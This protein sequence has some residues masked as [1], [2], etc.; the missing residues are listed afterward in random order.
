DQGL[1][2]YAEAV[3]ALQGINGNDI[4]T[5]SAVLAQI[6]ILWHLLSFKDDLLAAD[7]FPDIAISDKANSIASVSAELEKHGRFIELDRP[8]YAG[9]GGNPPY[10]RPERA[11]EADPSTRRYF[12]GGFDRWPGI[13]VEANL[14]ALFVY[15]AL[16]HWCKPGNKWGEGS[17]KLGFVLP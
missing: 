8:V 10:V 16:D 17:G 9:V 13:S 11:P 15:R 14:Y 1:A 3:K 7:E 2:T 4:N 5:F 6:Q 12:E